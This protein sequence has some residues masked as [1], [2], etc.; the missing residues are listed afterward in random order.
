[1]E[2][3]IITSNKENILPYKAKENIMLEIFF[4][5]QGVVHYKFITEGKTVN[6]EMHIDILRRLGVAFRRKRL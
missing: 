2:I 4:D 6:K 5:C 3:N 1:M